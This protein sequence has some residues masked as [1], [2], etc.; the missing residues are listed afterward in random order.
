MRREKGERERD[1][2]GAGKELGLGGR[3][4]G[5]EACSRENFM[6]DEAVVMWLLEGWEVE[7]R[8]W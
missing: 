6:P 7:D 4:G 3:A 1:I 2:R 5:L 8:R